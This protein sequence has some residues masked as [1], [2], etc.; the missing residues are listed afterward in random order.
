MGHLALDDRVG[1][2]ECFLQVSIS[3]MAEEVQVLGDRLMNEGSGL[4]HRVFECHDRGGRIDLLLDQI[5]SVGSLVASVRDDCGH[6]LAD[7]A[8]PIDRED[9]PVR[10]DRAGRGEM[11]G[12]W[13]A[14]AVEV[15]GGE[16]RPD[17]RRRL[18]R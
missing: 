9:R 3:A 8:N 17:A 16:D 18:R 5:Q 11:D 15:G 12:K 4:C 10:G 6:H 1:V 2:I 7:E 14:R 13:Q